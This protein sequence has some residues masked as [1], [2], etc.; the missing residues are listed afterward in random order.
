[1]ALAFDG[2]LFFVGVG[3]AELAE[4]NEVWR[5]ILWRTTL[6]SLGWA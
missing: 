4:T 3:K 5:V 2:F 6:A 1:M